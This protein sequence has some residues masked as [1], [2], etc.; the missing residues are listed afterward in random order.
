MPKLSANLMTER[1]DG[2]CWCFT[3]DVLALVL[4]NILASHDRMMDLNSR[5]TA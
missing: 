4:E 1:T 3:H 5:P 2:V